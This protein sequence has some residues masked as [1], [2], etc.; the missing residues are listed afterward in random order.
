MTLA[1]ACAAC[2]P[3]TTNSPSRTDTSPVSTPSTSPSTSGLPSL[4]RQ[5]IIRTDK[6]LTV[7][8]ETTSCGGYASGT[9]FVVG[10]NLV[11]TVASVVAGVQTI[12]VR[13]ANG[14]STGS[15]VGVDTDRQVALV[16]TAQDLSGGSMLHLTVEEPVQG[17]EY[18]TI[19]YPR[20]RQQTPTDGTVGA[21]GRAEDVGGK[22]ITGL[23][24]LIADTSPE[25]SGAPVIDMHG[26]VVGLTD[27]RVSD[28]NGGDFAISAKVAGPLI[29]AWAKS[30]AVI[31]P[32]SCA[33]MPKSAVT[34]RSDHPDAPG[35]AVA[36]RGY[37]DGINDGD[38]EYAPEMDAGNSIGFDVAFG[39][40]SG[41]LKTRLGP[42]ERFR[43]DRL[44]V[45]ARKVALETV[46]LSDEITDTADVSFTMTTKRA[47]PDKCT[48]YH[49]RY[50]VRLASG[51]W[52]LDD[53]TNLANNAT[54]C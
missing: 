28:E 45:T 33:A 9:G 37:F 39:T 46:V 41:K 30:P 31:D 29:D 16:R 34:S 14:V 53:R 4:T 23:L 11:A 24:Q 6:S 25:S 18:V 2:T 40:L 32:P 42:Y 13:G 44:D 8:L 27:A 54:A 52:T 1:T 26:Q 7:R 15:V 12:A 35:I 19:G 20:G 48:Y 10:P 36:L 22:R 5:E 38:R 50:K 3:S 43:E 47:G 51:A 21:L 49:F 17:D